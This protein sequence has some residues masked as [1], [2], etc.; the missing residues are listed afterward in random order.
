MSKKP[1][2]TDALAKKAPAPEPAPVPSVAEVP[3]VRLTDQRINTTLRIEPALLR[4]LKFAALEDGRKVNDLILEGVHHVLSLR[5]A[6]P[7]A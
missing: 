6:R 7:A 3:A 5:R 2:L 1:T 4:E